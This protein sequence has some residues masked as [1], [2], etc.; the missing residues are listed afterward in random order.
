MYILGEILISSKGASQLLSLPL[1][2]QC[3]ISAV[4]WYNKGKGKG[5]LNERSQLLWGK[6]ID[7][8]RDTNDG[9]FTFFSEIFGNSEIRSEISSFCSQIFS[10]EILWAPS[11]LRRM[12]V[13]SGHPERAL[14][15]GYK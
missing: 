5:K 13:L 9:I 2:A 15:D 1:Q 6:D 14:R 7:L 3:D 10:R 11:N 8:N 12:D 4:C